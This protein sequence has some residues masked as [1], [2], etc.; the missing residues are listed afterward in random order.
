MVN[1]DMSHFENFI[2]FCTS[3]LSL[4]RHAVVL[5]LAGCAIGYKSFETIPAGHVGYNSLF[6]NVKLKE[7]G[8]GFTFINPLATMVTVNLRKKIYSNT[9]SVASKEGLEIAVN[10]DIVY[11]LDKR[12][13]RDTFIN[14]GSGY[15]NV[16]LIPQ[17]NSCVR[18]A[19]AGY[20]AKDLYNDK[21][22]IE[23]KEKI[24]NGLTKTVV[25]GIIIED[26]LINKIVLPS[27]LRNSI[28]NKLQAEQSMQKM[29]FTL[30]QERKECE[31]KQIEALGIKSFQDTVAQ[32]ISKE[33]L[34][35]KGIT[36]TEELAK[37]TN[38]KIVIIGNSKNGLPLIFSDN[39]S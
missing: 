24:V 30:A 14:V 9:S 2:N 11:R 26:V 36:A 7:Y 20:E 5:G 18:D 39:K 22:R 27:G 33:L 31:R 23:I 4:R 8:S 34:E 38:T 1:K 16:L 21:I 6:G 25:D 12:A 35:W 13:A 17:L 10:I 28:E 32:G 29:D 19:I 3:R 37:S 15:E